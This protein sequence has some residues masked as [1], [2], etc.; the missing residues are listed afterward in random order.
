MKHICL[1]NFYTS[2]NIG[3]NQILKLI[4]EVVFLFWNPSGINL[5]CVQQSKLNVLINI[6]NNINFDKTFYD[7]QCISD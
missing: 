7:V 5:S 1:I 4:I 3:N 6:N 2:M